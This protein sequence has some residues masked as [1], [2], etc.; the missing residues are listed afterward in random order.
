MRNPI[1]FH[2][3]LMQICV[4]YFLQYRPST[5]PFLSLYD[6]VVSV[7]DPPVLSF[8]PPLLLNFDVDADADLDAHPAFFYFDADPDPQH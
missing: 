1:L 3:K 6:S 8:E 7:C 4:H 2:V 5:A